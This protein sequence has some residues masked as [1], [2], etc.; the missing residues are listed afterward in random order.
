MKHKVITHLLGIL[1]LGECKAIRQVCFSAV[2]RMITAREMLPKLFVYVPQMALQ[3]ALLPVS[4][5]APINFRSDYSEL[6]EA[7]P[8]DMFVLRRGRLLHAIMTA[9]NETIMV[10]M[11]D[12]CACDEQPLK[13]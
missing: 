1:Q 11:P 8:G 3:G 2:K 10:E 4:R 6:D 12:A 7:E 9:V 13:D 5:E